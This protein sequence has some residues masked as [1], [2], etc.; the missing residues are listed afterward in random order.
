V[1][2][3][4]NLGLIRVIPRAPAALFKG[5]PDVKVIRT[6]SLGFAGA[7]EGDRLRWINSFRRLLDGLDGPLQVVI[8]VATGVGSTSS[9]EASPVDFDDMRGADLSFVDRIARSPSAHRFETSLITSR[10]HASRLEQVKN[11]RVRQRRIS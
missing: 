9:D 5:A 4:L 1:S 7:A 3:S 11:R 6:G 2:S 8:E 10:V